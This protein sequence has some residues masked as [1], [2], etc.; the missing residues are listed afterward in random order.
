MGG[1]SGAVPSSPAHS[2]NEKTR[3]ITAERTRSTLVLPTHLPSA[4]V[5]A[6]PQMSS[7]AVDAAVLPGAQALAVL[8]NV[9]IYIHMCLSS[10]F[11][12]VH[13]YQRV[14]RV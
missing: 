7:R 4:G 1:V 13:Y 9:R 12:W 3:Q 6:Q 10:P 11:N 2:K 8:A 5:R 14:V